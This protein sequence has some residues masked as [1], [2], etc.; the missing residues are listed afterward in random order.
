MFRVSFLSFHYFMEP[1]HCDFCIL[2]IFNF[3]LFLRLLLADSRANPHAHANSPICDAARNGHTEIVRLLIGDP[4]VDPSA[5]DNRY[6]IYFILF[7]FETKESD[8]ILLYL[9]LFQTA[10]IISINLFFSNFNRAIRYS[11]R[12]G[13]LKIVKLLLSDPRTD[14]QSRDNYSLRYALVFDHKEVVN[15]LRCALAL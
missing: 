5:R 15:V 13:H 14:I 10:I 6:F 3:Y 2:K 4:R 11:A 1:L 9:L 12:H 8:N 7:L